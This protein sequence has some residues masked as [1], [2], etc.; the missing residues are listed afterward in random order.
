MSTFRR[1]LITAGMIVAVVLL[2]KLF[3]FVLIL[4]LTALV[5]AA[6]IA[7]GFGLGYVLWAGI[8]ATWWSHHLH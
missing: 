6:L 1:F 4:V 2:I 7:L 8:V 5:M 3:A